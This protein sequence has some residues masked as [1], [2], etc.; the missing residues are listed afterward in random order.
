MVWV[1]GGFTWLP[2]R[3]WIVLMLVCLFRYPVASC[4]LLALVLFAGGALPLQANDR[5]VFPE[6]PKIDWKAVPAP[7][8][9]SRQE[10][11]LPFPAVA[12][13]SAPF[14]QIPGAPGLPGSPTPASQATPA[15][16]SPAATPATAPTVTPPAAPQPGAPAPMP[17]KDPSAVKEQITKET[18][19]SLKARVDAATELTD[20]QKLQASELIEKARTAINNAVDLSSNSL[21]NWQQRTERLDEERKAEQARVD[22]ALRETQSRPDPYTSLPQLE[23]TLAS[24]QQELVQTQTELAQNEKRLGDRA[25]RQ[26]AIKERLAA[27]PI[28]IDQ[29]KSDL[30]KPETGADPPLIVEARR[31]QLLAELKWLENEPAALQAEAAFLAA[32][33]A[34]NLI[35]LRRQA[36]N[37]IV[38]RLKDEVAEWQQRVQRAKSSDAM[39]RTRISL[40]EAEAT[41]IPQLKALFLAN[42]KTIE[43]EVSVR[44]KLRILNDAVEETKAQQEIVQSKR[45]ELEHREKTLGTTTSFGVRLREQGRYLPDVNLLSHE[46]RER[47]TQN[48][49]AHIAYMEARENRAELDHLNRK[50]EQMVKEIIDSSDTVDVDVDV[51]TGEVRDAFELRQKDLTELESVYESYVL[52]LD[53]LDIEQAALIKQVVSFKQYIDRRIL[54]VPTHRL[55]QFKEIIEDIP[56]VMFVF[57]A[58]TWAPYYRAFVS[59][60]NSVPSIYVIAGIVWLLLLVTQ[61]KIKEN[62]RLNGQRASSRLNTKMEPT[63]EAVFWTFLKSVVAPFPLLFLSWRGSQPGSEIQSVSMFFYYLSIWFWWLEAV[64]IIC[65]SGGLGSAHFQWPTRV[66]E[67][68]TQQLSIFITCA[69]PLIVITGILR[70]EYGTDGSSD[71][72]VRV[73]NV[74]FFLMV[75]FTLYRLT[76]RRSGI[77]KEWIEAHKGGWIDRLSVVWNILVVGLPILF[78]VLTVLGYSYAVS[79]LTVRLAQTVMLASGMVFGRALL[80]RWLTLRQR[81]LAIAHAREV[82]AA[83]AEVQSQDE[84]VNPAVLGAQEARTNLADVSAQSKRLLN[85]TIFML[86]L[87]WIWYIWRDVLPALQ[88]LNQIRVPLLPLTLDKLLS[89]ILELILFATAARNIPGLIEITLLERLPIDRSSRYAIGAIIQYTIVLIGL[90]AIGNSLGI[91][92]DKLQWLV[93]ALTFSLG[94]GLQEIFAN[95]VSG[96][97]ILFE[98]PVRVGDTVTLDNVTGT[99]SRIRIRSTSIID[100]DRKEYIVPNKEFITGKLLNWTL[101]DTTNRILLPIQTSH[102]ADPQQ[103][104]EILL[105]IATTQQHVLSDPAPTVTFSGFGDSALN[106][107]VAIYLPTMEFRQETVHQIHSRTLKAFREAGIELAYPQRGLNIR[108][109]VPWTV[110]QERTTAVADKVKDAEEDGE[111]GETVKPGES[112]G[113]TSHKS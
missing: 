4:C 35:P 47:A 26:R 106:F 111:D 16:P 102:A 99:V 87:V 104:R 58:A 24:K 107:N 95:F 60:F 70:S 42:A 44:E 50:I 41:Q 64:R 38:S 17:D 46:I 20:A 9:V 61:G 30:A 73:L 55:L 10:G 15:T 36:L 97:I 49:E 78:A 23:Q 54:W 57:T 75:A 28:L 84:A 85:T 110:N 103:V 13:Q 94:F 96:I 3:K 82:R 1:I 45:A 83:L 18:L 63:W 11:P 29:Y 39:T 66:N 79:R 71:A 12:Q 62:I 76:S 108:S 69:A 92:W 90:L 112:N 72:V 34:A 88:H 59:D 40:A 100:Y 14:M 81:R 2:K 7:P 67:V 98:Q 80:F 27:I 68:V 48:E 77:F 65:R 91:E 53:Q 56:G 74:V 52:A 21:R 105:K 33:E 37:A 32:Q 31:M 22:A 51:L 8:A 113:V 19:D 86:S 101:S 93:A 6:T 5:P 25:A 89:A 43:N 109:T